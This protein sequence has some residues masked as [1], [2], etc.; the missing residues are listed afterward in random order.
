M[1]RILYWVTTGLIILVVGIGSFA[2]IF[3]VEAVRQGVLHVGFPEY[4][5]PFLGVM[6][7]LG[8]IAVVVPVFRRLREAAY[9][10][11]I[12]YFIG[13]T[14]C[15]IAVGDGFDK[16]AVTLVIL[17]ITVLSYWYSL[18]LYGEYNGGVHLKTA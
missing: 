3:K 1:N 12:F 16:Y 18:K 13:A 8:T 11:I 17:A 2:D 10:G 6:K 14:Y 5:L 4:I 7:L 15:H 9:A